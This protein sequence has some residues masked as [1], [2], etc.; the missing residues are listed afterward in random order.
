MCNTFALFFPCNTFVSPIPLCLAISPI[1][2]TLCR[3]SAKKGVSVISECGLCG[4]EFTDMSD[5]RAACH[6]LGVP[7]QGIAK[8]EHRADLDED[9]RLELMD[10]CLAVK[11]WAARGAGGPS[12]IA[13][14]G[15][16]NPNCPPVFTPSPQA[17]RSQ[18]DAKEPSTKRKLKSTNLDEM[19]AGCEQEV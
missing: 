1:H 5:R 16:V 17:L 15:E 11:A 6:V 9:T 12:P 8:C 7:G 19:F 14:G 2:N 18:A 3:M 4:V 13:G 10:C